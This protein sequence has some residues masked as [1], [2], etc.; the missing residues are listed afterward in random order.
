MFRRG[1]QK[2]GMMQTNGDILLASE[3]LLNVASQK[4]SQNEATKFHN[5]A[6]WCPGCCFPANVGT[7]TYRTLY[8]THQTL[9]VSKNSHEDDWVECDQRRVQRKPEGFHGLSRPIHRMT[10]S[11]SPFPI[12]QKPTSFVTPPSA[13]PGSLDSAGRKRCRVRSGDEGDASECIRD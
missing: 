8:A 5:G 6:T 13:T 1:E 12:R 2:F 4:S 10:M 7:S 3:F 11:R 9:S